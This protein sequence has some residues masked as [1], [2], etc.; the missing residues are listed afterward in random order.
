MNLLEQAYKKLYPASQTTLN[1]E[2]EYSGH[3]KGHGGRIQLSVLQKKLTCRVSNKWKHVTDSIQTG[4]LQSLIAK[5]NKTKQKTTE[6][7]LYHA[8]IHALSKHAP[9]YNFDP[10]L[11]EAF[12]TLNEHYFNN[13]ME[14]PNLT[15][16]NS[17]RLLGTYEYSTDTITISQV[18]LQNKELLHYV[19]YH[20]MLHKHHGYKQQGLRTCSHNTQFR[21]DEHKFPNWQELEKKMQHLGQHQQFPSKIFKT[22]KNVVNYL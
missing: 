16:R 2:L 15:Y 3:Y 18:L 11:S 13:M 10:V 1:F 8:Y 9:K 12:D 6:M 7:E 22:V 21:N 5:L 19:L 17:T 4:F 14:K 20:E